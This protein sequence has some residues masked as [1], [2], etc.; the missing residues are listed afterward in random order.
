M[1]R[2][3]I[4]EHIEFIINEFKRSY[5]YAIHNYSKEDCTYLQGMINGATIVQAFLEGYFEGN[6]NGND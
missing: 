5:E 2:Q 1:D 6:K 3:A 4:L